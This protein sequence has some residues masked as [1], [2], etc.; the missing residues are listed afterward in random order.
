MNGEDEEIEDPAELT[1]VR[2]QARWVHIEAVLFGIGLT[3][4]AVALPL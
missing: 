4:V 2:R 1:Q 3:A